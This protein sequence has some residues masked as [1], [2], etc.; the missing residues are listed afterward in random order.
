MTKKITTVSLITF[1]LLVTVDAGRLMHPAAEAGSLKTDGSDLTTVQRG[2]PRW[3]LP[4]QTCGSTRGERT[5]EH[6]TLE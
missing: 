5:F 3:C 6:R 2:I 1:T 4:R